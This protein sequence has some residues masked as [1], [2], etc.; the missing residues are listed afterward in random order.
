[1][2]RPA[3]GHH[4]DVG[5]LHLHADLV[6][7]QGAVRGHAHAQAERGAVTGQLKDILTHQRLTAGEDDH[8][9]GKIGDLLEQ[10]LP[11]FGGEIPLRR[12]QFGRAAAVDT[13]K[14][15]FLGGF[16]GDPFRD[17]FFGHSISSRLCHK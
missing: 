13:F 2:S 15:A 8:R 17:K 7:H 3:T 12:G 5:F 14:V 4:L 6:G 1:L 9:L 11:L 10:F 16:P